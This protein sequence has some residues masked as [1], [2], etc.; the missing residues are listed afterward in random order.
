MFLSKTILSLPKALSAGVATPFAAARSFGRAV[1]APGDPD[2]KPLIITCALT[3]NVPTREMNPK[4]PVTSQEIANDVAECYEAG[5][6]LF[7]IHS[8][9]HHQKPCQNL[10]RFRT[11]VSLIKEKCP[12]AIVQLSTGARAG[13]SD[14]DRWNIVRLCP[15]MG[16]FTTGSNNLAK[17]IYQN[18]PKFILQLAQ[19]FKETGVVP[20]IECFDQGHIDNAIFLV[21][22]G[23]LKMPLHFDFVMGTAGGISA[24]VR[25]LAHM[26]SSIPHTCTWT[27]APIGKRQFPILATAIAMGGN[28]RCGLEDNVYNVEG[29]LTSNPE[30]VARVARLAKEL[31]RP[32][33]TAAEAR[34]ILSLKEQNKDRILPYLDSNH[35]LFPVSVEEK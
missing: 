32:I 33:A 22:K 16:S 27:V 13:G 30:Q 23:L 25:N 29:K 6:R 1:F 11:T 17:I 19:V 12:D 4:V 18:S 8:R 28:T 2:P 31:G 24:T 3:G 15:E 21:N 20:E 10:D 34:A 35:P 26:A 14:A 7:H 9:D 5:A